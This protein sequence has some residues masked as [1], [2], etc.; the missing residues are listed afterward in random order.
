[1][2]F[3]RSDWAEKLTPENI[4]DQ[5]DSRLDLLSTLGGA[6][7]RSILSQEIFDLRNWRF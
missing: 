1:M 4:Q 6:L 2:Q 5:I 7:Y 3:N